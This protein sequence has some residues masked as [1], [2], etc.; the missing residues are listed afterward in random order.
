MG[1]TQRLMAYISISRLIIWAVLIVAC[2]ALAYESSCMVW[3]EKGIL[4]VEY[5]RCWSMVKTVRRMPV[6]EISRVSV[7]WGG[8]NGGGA[9]GPRSVLIEGRRGSKIEFGTTIGGFAGSL[10][11]VAYKVESL[12]KQSMCMQCDFT[13]VKCYP[14]SIWNG[15]GFLIFVAGGLFY[16]WKR[17]PRKEQD[18]GR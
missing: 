15:V 3:V 14:V 1:S 5:D 2:L 12:I 6:S 11:G 9:S 13:P 18:D 7:T 8:G 16:I 4:S 10:D 17:I